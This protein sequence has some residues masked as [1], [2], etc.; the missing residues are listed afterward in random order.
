MSNTRGPRGHT[1]LTGPTGASGVKGETGPTGAGGVKGETGA[2]GATG[3]V[4]Q[5]KAVIGYAV[6]CVGVAA[7]ISLA[8]VGLGRADRRDEVTR[9]VICQNTVTADRQQLL[10][11]R[12]KSGHELIASFHLTIPEATKIIHQ[13]LEAS[14]Q[15]RKKLQPSQPRSACTSALTTLPKR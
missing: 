5:Y 14:A 9:G 13:N 10:N 2:T 8:Y 7:A 1:G 6:L 3:L 12:T 4:N 15:E 11:L